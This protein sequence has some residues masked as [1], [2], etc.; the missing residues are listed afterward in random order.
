MGSVCIASSGGGAA[1]GAAGASLCTAGGGTTATGGAVL[2]DA[3][4]GA[5]GAPNG[6]ATGAGAGATGM[7]TGTTAACTGSAPPSSGAGSP[8]DWPASPCRTSSALDGPLADQLMVEEIPNYNSPRA[9]KNCRRGRSARSAKTCFWAAAHCIKS[10]ASCTSF[11]RAASD[12]PAGARVAGDVYARNACAS[13]STSI[14]SACAASGVTNV[15]SRVRPRS[16]RTKRKADRCVG[17]SAAAAMGV[18][19]GNS[20]TTSLT[21]GAGAAPLDAT[22]QS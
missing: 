18:R 1:G 20:A 5:V 17:P 21:G 2:S 22:R 4:G 13:G 9:A 19:A 16:S 11:S 3:T 12:E 7:G 10:C 6:A 8:P 15:D 14:W